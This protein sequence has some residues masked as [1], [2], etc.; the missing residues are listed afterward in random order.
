M[1]PV[2]DRGVF[3]E[4]LD[5][6]FQEILHPDGRQFSLT[7]VAE[8]TAK[9]GPVAVTQQHLSRLRNGAS[10]NP[11][12]EQITAIARFFGISPKYFVGDDEEVERIHAE[13]D[14]LLAMRDK[15]VKDIAL[16]ASRMDTESIRLLR[17][18]IEGLESIE[19][20]RAKNPYRPRSRTNTGNTD[21]ESRQDSDE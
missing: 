8:G 17:S 4:R 9:V 1:A 19:T 18:A 3:A 6:L 5:K 21:R 2:D 12:L 15:G 13:F 10:R 20:L 14:L 16:R 7:E 11:G